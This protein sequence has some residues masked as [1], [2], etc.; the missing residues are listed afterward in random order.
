[1][2]SAARDR[3]VSW[4]QSDGV[5]RTCRDVG[6]SVASVRVE[7]GGSTWSRSTSWCWRGPSRPIRSPGGCRRA[8]RSPSSGSPSRR[9]ADASSPSRSRRGTPRSA[10]RALDAIAKGDAVLV[11]GQ[12]VR[13]FY[14][15]GAGARSLTEVVATGIKTAR[16]GPRSR[17]SV[18]AAPVKRHHEHHARCGASARRT[19]TCAAAALRGRS[20]RERARGWSAAG[21][22]RR[23][24]RRRARPP[25][26][27]CA[28]CVKRSASPGA[29]RSSTSSCRARTTGAVAVQRAATRTRRRRPLERDRRRS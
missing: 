12:L 5:V 1:M 19:W 21:S 15:S 6:P 13:R 22:R 29:C 24:R 9:R 16:S 25:P 26:A 11:H 3:C 28:L 18:E 20:P 8:T 27:S 7:E 2:P 17:K 14:R 23:P 10:A 4:V